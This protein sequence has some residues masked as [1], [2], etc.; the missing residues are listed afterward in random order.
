MDVIMQYMG[1]SME[2][3]KA[4]FATKRQVFEWVGESPFFDPTRFR[5]EGQGFKKV[6]PE[7]KM[8]AQFVEWAQGQKERVRDSDPTARG[9]MDKQERIQHALVYFHKKAEFDALA[10]ETAD[11]ALVKEGFNGV[12]VRLWTG[13]AVHQW[14]ELK[15]IMDQVRGWV[16]GEQGI[17]KTLGEE[18]EEGLE[19]L[20]LRAKNELKIVV[21]EPHEKG[22]EEAVKRLDAVVIAESETASSVS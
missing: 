1:L 17:V 22:I 15:L 21:E 14:K 18:G 9:G 7:R 5:S 16:G 6:K 19:K 3:W 20:V 10:R 11:K 12:K 4:G 13:L 2:R 8:Y